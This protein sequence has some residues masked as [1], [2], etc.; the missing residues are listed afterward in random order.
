MVWLLLFDNTEE[1][2]KVVMVGCRDKI[3]I[4]I[5]KRKKA[6]LSDPGSALLSGNNR[7]G[8]CTV[9]GIWYPD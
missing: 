6:F 2:G 9:K 5:E 1:E 7:T 3:E 4:S 8:A